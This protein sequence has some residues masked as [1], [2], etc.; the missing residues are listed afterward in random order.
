MSDV[1]RTVE[2]GNLVGDPE[3]TEY[4]NGDKVARF[5]I[6]V[7]DTWQDNE[8]EWQDRANFFDVEV[9][10][11]EQPERIANNF[12]K[13]DRA[14]VE[15]KLRQDRWEDDNGNNRSKVKIRA[16]RVSPDGYPDGQEGSPEE[17]LEKT[18]VNE[19][20]T[21]N[22]EEDLFSKDKTPI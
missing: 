11:N 3:L 15:G 14:I 6:A 21:A 1:N 5:S 12:E 18:E 17:I 16:Y 9:R 8:G 19:T 7:S 4:D 22:E 2:Q 13:G 20:E 10:G